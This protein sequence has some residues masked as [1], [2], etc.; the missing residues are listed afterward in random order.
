VLTKVEAQALAWG[1][2]NALPTGMRQR[3]KAIHLTP[4]LNSGMFTIRVHMVPQSAEEPE[5]FIFTLEDL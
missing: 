5:S 2:I 4:R 3:F 1:V